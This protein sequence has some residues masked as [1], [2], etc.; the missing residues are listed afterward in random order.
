MFF[1]LISRLPSKNGSLKSPNQRTPVRIDLTPRASVP[2]CP[3]KFGAMPDKLVILLLGPA[4]SG[5]TTF[6]KHLLTTGR[7][8]D[9]R[10]FPN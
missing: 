8:H 9:G 6:V 7:V 4:R 1:D 5:K 10:E 3:S 2:F